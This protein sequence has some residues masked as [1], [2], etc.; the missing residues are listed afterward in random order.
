MKV[1]AGVGDMVGAGVLGRHCLSSYFVGG[2]YS[3]EVSLHTVSG[4]QKRSEVS[5]G[6]VFWYSVVAHA[7]ML[8]QTL[9]EVAVGLIFSY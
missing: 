4:M 8:A 7:L 2:R 3:N 6:S 1:G 9:F 5:V